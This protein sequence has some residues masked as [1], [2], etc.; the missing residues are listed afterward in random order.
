MPKLLLVPTDPQ[1]LGGSS[2]TFVTC[3]SFS[4]LVNLWTVKAVTTKL[5]YRGI[6][7]CSGFATQWI[8]LSWSLLIPPI[9]DALGL[10]HTQFL[11]TLRI[12]LTVPT[13]VPPLSFTPDYF[14]YSESKP[15]HVCMTGVDA[16]VLLVWLTL[17]VVFLFSDITQFPG[18][19]FISSL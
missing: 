10:S 2:F 4:Q 7:S 12:M 9:N 3:W 14:L 17:I 19:D 16:G 5:N 15:L 11:C 6:S 1:I 8:I 13:R 18:L